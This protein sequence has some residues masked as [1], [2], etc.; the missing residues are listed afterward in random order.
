MIRP[1][2]ENFVAIMEARL[3][4]HDAERGPASWKGEDPSY[5]WGLLHNAHVH[6]AN[7]IDAGE[8]DEALKKAA[9]VANFAMMIADVLP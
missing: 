3:A 1:E 9:D 4:T 5:L 7:A 8:H 2:L 6:L